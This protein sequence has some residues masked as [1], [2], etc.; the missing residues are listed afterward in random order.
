MDRS[1]NDTRVDNSIERWFNAFFQNHFIPMRGVIEDLQAR[2][3]SQDE[4]IAELSRQL[5]NRPEPAPATTPPAADIIPDTNTEIPDIVRK[6]SDAD[7]RRSII[8][9]GIELLNTAP[10]SDWQTNRNN[11][12]YLGRF[13]PAIKAGLRTCELD[14]LAFEASNFKLFP[15]GALKISYP[16]THHAK[17][18]QRY[19]RQWIGD[20]KS[21]EQQYD[22]WRDS[23]MYRIAKNIKFSIETPA[24]FNRDRATLTKCAKI[25]K[26]SSRCTWFEFLVIRNTLVMKT[27][28]TRS[29]RGAREYKYYSVDQAMEIIE[30]DRRRSYEPDEEYIMGRVDIGRVDMNTEE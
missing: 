3:I 17:A 1:Q 2:I 18:M 20:T 10:V 4:T 24:R 13:V 30:E 23:R 8:V 21:R 6:M 26:S 11:P 19:L 28:R 27:R 15:S 16:T 29:G 14:H 5:S 9:S 7:S 12:E 22:D 25:L